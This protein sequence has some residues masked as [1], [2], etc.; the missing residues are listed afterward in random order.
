MIESLEVGCPVITYNNS[1]LKE[2][3]GPNVYLADDWYGIF[4]QASTILAQSDKERAATAKQGKKW[5]NQFA[6]KNSA[7][8]MKQAI[9]QL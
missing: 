5:A 4:E 9:D 6:W 2:L 8:V 3:T 1:S 7:K